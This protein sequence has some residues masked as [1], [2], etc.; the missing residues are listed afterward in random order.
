MTTYRTA[1]HEAIAKSGF[2]PKSPRWGYIPDA[3]HLRTQKDAGLRF[4]GAVGTGA[5]IQTSLQ[6][7]QCRIMNQGATGSCTGH[8]TAMAI[9]IAL[10]ASGAISP[11][12]PSPDLIYKLARIL[13][14]DDASR[15]LADIGAMPSYIPIALRQYGIAP[16]GAP[17]PDGRYS[18]V[19][20][21]DDLVGLPAA[22]PT[23]DVEPDLLV[24]ERAGLKL[25]TGDYRVNESG[26]AATNQII[27]ALTQ[28]IPAGIGIFVDTAFQ[29]WDP[30]TG[31]IQTID[32]NDPTGG[33]HWLAMSYTYVNP[34]L[35]VI[36][37]GPNSW[38]LTWP[39]TVPG[40]GVPGSPFWTPGHYEITAACLQRVMSDC[41]LFPTT[42]MP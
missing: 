3:D 14:R 26:P 20:G 27:T 33:G 41:L 23:V 6:Q 39:M 36:F 35:G 34:T 37:G 10:V 19:T 38:D 31:P 9:Y 22:K 16:I 1:V 13:A 12:V 25:V 17:T 15:G 2:H 42:V 18:D 8:G 40:D 7:Y 24:L 5:N 32:L 28:K 21:P 29:R 30:T 11:Q 4:G